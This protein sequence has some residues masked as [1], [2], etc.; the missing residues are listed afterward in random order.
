MP[1]TLS[2]AAA[3]PWSDWKRHWRDNVSVGALAACLETGAFALF[4]YMFVQDYRLPT[5]TAIALLVFLAFHI[6]IS[7]LHAFI[8]TH[9][10]ISASL[11]EA[12]S[13]R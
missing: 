1:A 11:A 13:A 2:P 7:A 4:L 6:G 12:R 5:V 3:T 9:P 8:L 10:K